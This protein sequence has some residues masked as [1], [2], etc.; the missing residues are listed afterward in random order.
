[1]KFSYYEL[2]YIREGLKAL[3]TNLHS[4]QFNLGEATSDEV[5]TNIKVVDGILTLMD[6]EKKM[7]EKFGH[8]MK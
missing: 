5:K 8:T 6:G 1:M 4:V 7:I 2:W 3:K